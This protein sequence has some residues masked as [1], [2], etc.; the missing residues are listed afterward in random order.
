MNN[1]Y[2]KS[3]F[4]KHYENYT[5]FKLT[6]DMLKDDFDLIV[7]SIDVSLTARCNLKCKN[8]GSLMQYYKDPKDIELGLI[9]K[10]LNRF[11][12]VVDRVVR[13][14]V[15]GGEPF[16]YPHL[17]DIVEY[18]NS[19]DQIIRVVFPTNGTVVPED[20]KLYEA[21]RNQKNHVRISHYEA[22]DQKTSRM[23]NKLEQEQIDHSI[24]QFGVN[25]YLWYD[26][27]GFNNRYRTEEN[28]IKQYKKCEVEWYSLYRGKMYPC[29][30]TA[31]GIDL[32]FIE[33]EG[34]FIDL[35]NEKI[36]L[37]DLKK[38]IQKFVYEREYHPCCAYC[39]RG[40]EHCPIVPV[41]EQLKV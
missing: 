38:Q 37:I 6:E 16:L 18:L 23:L 8:C 39:D 36:P 7:G 19:K 11:F 3:F 9:I 30:R 17:S 13:V 10:T 21:L 20:P 29:P 41:A 35:I 2:N 1:K 32:G 28:L 25:E 14:N 12:S 31:H 22:Y 24:K 15:I 34:N 27:G 33:P 40:T 5:S 4:M 26:F